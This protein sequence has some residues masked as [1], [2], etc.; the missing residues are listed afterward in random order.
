M[1]CIAAALC[2]A[3]ML[4]AATPLPEGAG[5]KTVESVCA[6]CHSLEIVTDKRWD[7]EQWQI[8]VGEMIGF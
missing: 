3:T 6:A 5:R 8:V 2:G 7:R 1:K 4:F